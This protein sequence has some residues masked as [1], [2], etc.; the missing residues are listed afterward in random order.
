VIPVDVVIRRAGGFLR[1]RDLLAVGVTDARIRSA[2]ARHSIFR[3]RQ[4]WYSV[5]GWH[6]Q[7]VR[8]VRVG[9]RLTS[10]SALESYGLPVPR[11]A[12]LH[13]AV[14]PNANRLRRPTD[15][16]RR[17][18]P[19]DAAVVHWTDRRSGGSRWRVPLADALVAVL[20]SE[21]REVAIA[22][23]SAALHHH[24]I[25]ARGLDAVFARAPVRVRRWRAMVSV[26]DES[27]GETFFRTRYQESGRPCEQQVTIEGIG[28]FDFRVS[29]HV[30]VEVDGGQHDPAWSGGGASSWANDLDRDAAMTIRGNRVI[31]IGYR[32]LYGDWGTVLA[33]IDR[34]V[35]DD[36][37]L[38]ARRRQHPYRPRTQRKRRRSAPK[39]SP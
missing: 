25:T 18:T 7:A 33:A 26:L 28:R 13:V 27:H 19:I 1:R 10:L 2:L 37:A 21:P 39:W 3:V 34:A 38:A 6:E 9:G 32:Q 29:E 5:P 14:P 4:G 31:H 23:C 24:R 17:I 36:A 15:R 12:E 8:A 35:A 16:R 22:A 30:Y 20:I 11:S